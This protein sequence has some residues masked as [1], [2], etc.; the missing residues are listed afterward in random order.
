MATKDDVNT[1][2]AGIEDA[3]TTAQAASTSA[4]EATKKVDDLATHFS[5]LKRQVVTKEEVSRLIQEEV[6]AKLSCTGTTLAQGTRTVLFGGLQTHTLA[7]AQ[8]WITSKLKELKLPP[9]TDM[10]IKGDE[11]TGIV[12]AKIESASLVEQVTSAVTRAN[13]S[14]GTSKVW[15]K[16]DKPFEERT[17]LSFLLG[18]RYQLKEWGYKGSIRVSE[19][20]L[21]LLFHGKPVL[22]A[23]VT[24]CK[25]NLKWSD[26]RWLEWAELQDSTELKALVQKANDNIRKSSELA[27]GKGDGKGKS[28]SSA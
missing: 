22:S 26:K 7:S 19:S 3:K 25:M 15:C 16:E 9:P 12:F 21:T 18:L 2:K 5:E 13:L 8:E 20:N 24:D 11:F 23:S 28:A 27:E 17:A 6:H 1:L 14:S 4:E 10:Y